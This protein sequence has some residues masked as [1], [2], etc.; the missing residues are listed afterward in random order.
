MKMCVR[1]TIHT[2][3]LYD[4]FL[5][6]S[7]SW[8]SPK[9]LNPAFLVCLTSLPMNIPRSDFRHRTSNISCSIIIDTNRN[10]EI[11]LSLPSEQGYRRG[12]RRSRGAIAGN[13]VICQS[14][15]LPWGDLTP[16]RFSN[17]LDV[18]ERATTLVDM[19]GKV[20]KDG[21]ECR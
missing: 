6:W 8:L 12:Y 14:L 11:P 15:F 16:N 4:T 5:A 7:I 18:Q 19:L 21:D 9:F 10:R 20:V 3:R 2:S 1:C 17:Q 13:R